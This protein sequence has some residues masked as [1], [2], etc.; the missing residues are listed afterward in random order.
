MAGQWN[1][2]CLK[3]DFKI[4]INNEL[5]YDFRFEIRARALINIEHH[6]SC[7]IY[8]SDCVSAH[9]KANSLL[10]NDQG[11]WTGTRIHPLTHTFINWWYIHSHMSFSTLPNTSTRWL[12]GVGGRTAD[13]LI[14]GPGHSFKHVFIYSK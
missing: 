5:N 1:Y 6:Y 7:D 4:S 14:S 8:S 3:N 13:P 12:Q 9:R 2:I 10:W 11:H